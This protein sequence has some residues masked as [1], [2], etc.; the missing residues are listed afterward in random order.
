MPVIIEVI[1]D[2]PQAESQLLNISALVLALFA[3]VTPY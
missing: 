2:E 3:F 1:D